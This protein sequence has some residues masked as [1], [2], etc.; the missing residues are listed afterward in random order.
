MGKHHNK[1]RH[2][3]YGKLRSAH[4]WHYGEDVINTMSSTWDKMKGAGDKDYGPKDGMFKN[5]KPNDEGVQ[6][7]K[8]LQTKLQAM[9][10]A[11]GK[12]LYEGAIDGKWG[13][14]SKKAAIA[15]EGGSPG[16]VLNKPAPI[17]LQSDGT[18]GPGPAAGGVLG[19]A[20]EK[21]VS[22]LDKPAPMGL[23]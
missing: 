3:G 13:P 18:S 4:N 5:G 1:K 17:G 20:P 10:G 19:G 7:I 8:D 6:F 11:D 22:V 15:A 14:L 21:K 12:P 16:S 23:Q 9:K 2:G